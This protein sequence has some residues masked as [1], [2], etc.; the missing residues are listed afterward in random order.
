MTRY[1]ALLRG[2]NV[3]GK[4]KIAMPELKL[5]F[6][7]HGFKN[8]ITYINSGNILFDSDLDEF[9]A[10]T[11][12]EALIKGDFGLTIIVGIITADELHEALSKAPEWWDN[13]PESKH[14]ALFVIP[15]MT[16]EEVWK[17]VDEV[18]PKYEN[19]TYYGKVIFWS[20]PITT[21]SR[22]RW[23]KIAQNKAIY[24]T[25]TIRNANTTK[26]LATLCEDH[27]KKKQ[28]VD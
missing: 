16:A 23:S 20:A 27:T 7:K 21:F 5:A 26:K 6:E 14:N 10:K 28:D 8:V 12:C 2:V 13:D 25:I 1:I 19:V 18:K 15:P 17:Q 3:G 11:T 22:T 4:N 24:N 9:A